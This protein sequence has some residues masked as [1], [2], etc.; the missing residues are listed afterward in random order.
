MIVYVIL[1]LFRELCAISLSVGGDQWIE[2]QLFDWN[3][4]LAELALVGFDHV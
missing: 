3:D 1:S 2:T 4:E